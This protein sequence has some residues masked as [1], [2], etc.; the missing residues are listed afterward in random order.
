[1]LVWTGVGWI[2]L[3]IVLVA[4]MLM[5][6]LVE[7][8]SGDD[9]YFQTHGWPMFAAI[10][11]SA[12]VIRSIAARRRR[13]RTRVLVDVETGEEVVWRP[14]DSF[15][16]IPLRFWPAIMFLLSAIDIFNGGD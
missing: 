15:M 14:Q 16:F 5:E 1:M 8:L 11:S 13:M 4:V 10:L 3:P 6:F 9:Q 7:L 2:V 12:L